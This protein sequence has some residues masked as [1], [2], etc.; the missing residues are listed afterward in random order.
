MLFTVGTQYYSPYRTCNNT[1]YSFDWREELE[2]SWAEVDWRVRPASNEGTPW[3]FSGF[4]K[5]GRWYP[6]L[7]PLLDGRLAIF[8]GL[9]GFDKGF[10]EMH[11]FEINSWIE[12]FDPSAFDPAAPERAWK[13]VDVA[14]VENS[15]FRTLINPG[16]K[17]TPC[18]ACDARCIESNKYDAFKL[19]PE[20]YLQPD[21]RIYLTREGDWVSL[22]T[23]DTAFMRRT[24]NTYWATLDDKE[25]E[26]QEWVPRIHE[27]AE[28]TR[29]THVLMNNC[30]RSYAVDNARDLRTLLDEE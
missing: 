12:V 7:V 22:R 9:V 29:E 3:T 2:T 13:A 11:I 15:P 25:G 21:G 30:Y 16:F 19:Y 27:L 18:V 20:N 4:M 5:R 17:P 6:S 10:P 28:Q 1:A 24:K 23:C 14:K 8:S 26:L